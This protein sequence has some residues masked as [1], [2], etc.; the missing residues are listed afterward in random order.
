MADTRIKAGQFFGVVGHGTDGYFLMTNADGTMSW[1]EGGASGPSV[2]SVDYPGDDTAADPAG[3][4]TVVLT[5]TGFAASGMTVSIGG[6]TAP[7]VAHDSNTQLTITTPAKAAGDYDIVVT[8]TVTG[9]S[10]TFVNG[11]SYNGIPTWTTA[12]GSLGTFESETTISTITLQATEPDGGTITF[13]ITNGALPTGLSLTGANIDGT[14]TAESST[15]LYSFTIE[16]IDDENQATPRNFSITVNASAITPSENFTINTYTGNGSTQSIEGKIGTA[17][18]FNG[19]SSKIDFSS[20]Q[21]PTT[22]VSFSFW[23]R[24]NNTPSSAATAEVLYNHFNGAQSY[25]VQIGSTTI[26]SYALGAGGSPDYL[27]YSMSA[28]TLWHHVVVTMGSTNGHVLYID[29]SP[30]ATDAALTSYYGGGTGTNNIGSSG[31]SKWFDGQIDQFRIFEKELSS[32]EV[33]TLYGENNA[34][35]FKSTTDIFGDGSAVA[36]YEFEEGA[37]DTGGVTGYIGSA[38]VFNGSSS[39]ISLPSSINTTYVTPTGSFS[40]STWVNFNTIGTAEQQIICFNTAANLELSL[41]T[42]SNTGKIVMRIYKSGASPENVYLVSTTTVSANTWYHVAIT[43][44]NGS[45]AL[46]INGSSEDTGTQTLTQPTTNIF[47]GERLNNSQ[48]LQGKIDQ[49]RFFNKALS[50]NEVTTLYGE[51]SASATKSTTDIFD[52][53]S[54]V[55]LYELE[56]NALGTG[57]GVIDSGQSAVFNGSSSKINLPS[58]GNTFENN[59]SYSLWFVLD[60]S[61]SGGI[62][63]LIA[64]Q[65]DYYNFAIIRDSDKKV[66][67]RFEYPGGGFDVLKSTS[68]FTDYGTWHHLTITKSSTTG[69]AIYIDGILEA[70]DPTATSNLSAMSNG[71]FLGVYGNGLQYWLDGKLDQ[72]RIYSSALSASD[73]TNLFNE[74]NAP[75]ANLVAHYKLDGNANDSAGSYNGT[76]T[77]ITYT[78]PAEFP[79]YDGTATNVSYGYDG[80]PTNVSFVG[81][82]FQP[83]FIWIKSRDATPSHKLFDSVRGISKFLSADAQDQEYTFSP[84]GVTSFDSNGFT[85]ADIT[86]GGYAVN[87]APGQTYTGANADYVAWAWKAGGS[88][89]PNNN[90]Q[91]DITSTVSANQDAGFSIV[92]YTGNSSFGQSVGHGLSQPPEMIFFKNLSITRDWRVYNYYHGATKFLQ[93]DGAGFGTFGS[94]NNTDPT[95]EVFYTTNSASADT[96]TNNSGNNYIAYCFH[97]V[98]G[99]QKLGSYTGTG[100]AGNAQSIGFQPKFILGKSYDNTE[101]WFIVDSQRGGNKY[102]KPN[103]SNAEATAGASITFTST[104][105]EF[106]GGSFNNSGMNFIYLAIA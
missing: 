62:S 39:K 88:V 48:Y 89:T 76:A 12:A 72:V 96:A 86:N 11:I 36:L 71:N 104:G 24:S 14:T 70:S 67:T 15:T 65:G 26:G 32:S 5:G 33:T 31:S 45:W 27:T 59:F 47:L 34:S 1:A 38:G 91:G 40:A 74:T 30:V 64:T 54:G 100:S 56:G 16:A 105:F 37:K 57:K 10:G 61:P 22:N 60:S 21:V 55:A 4:Q 69:A 87:G 8:N 46:Y 99:Y 52:D 94:F 85:I 41:N 81:T 2:T 58:F 77:S 51:T 95:S 73:V 106:T 79:T 50:L 98:V 63:N 80:T 6:T 25:G 43:H 18:D 49:V 101:D 78:D 23:F 20:Y 92:S 42:N 102:L 9:A 84:Y 66:E 90:T 53:G 75:T 17:A 3:G 29:G 28:D 103:L 44:N 68:T 97:S 13:N 83:D 19:S 93:L 82:S 35:L 7:S